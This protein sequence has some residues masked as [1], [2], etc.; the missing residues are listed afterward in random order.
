MILGL[1]PG[2][3]ELRAFELAGNPALG[4]AYVF[5]LS[6]V[7][8]IAGYLTLGLIRPWGERLFGR[9]VPVALAVIPGL[10]GGIAVVY[11]FD[12]AMLGALLH[13]QR[14]D[15]GLVTGTPF[16]IMLAAY[17]PIFVWGPL[18]L[19]AVLGY[20]WRRTRGAHTRAAHPPAQQASP[21][22]R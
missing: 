1:M 5:G 17:I 19:A 11:L 12:I 6:I 8:V 22:A 16:A 9:R 3:A 4:Y 20:W 14:P 13:G 2:T 18:E 21:T 10:L 7:Q 15:N